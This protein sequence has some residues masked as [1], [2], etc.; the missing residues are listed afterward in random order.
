M[1]FSGVGTLPA[2]SASAPCR[3][4]S[5]PFRPLSRTMTF[6]TRSIPGHRSE[7][8][9]M[10]RW[11]S[12]LAQSPPTLLRL[13]AATHRVSLPR[14]CTPAERLRR[15]RAALCRPAALRALYWSLDPATRAALQSLRATPGG[16]RPDDLSARFGPLRPLHVLRA[17]PTPRSLSERLLL[18]GLLLPRPATPFHPPRYLVPPE[19][20]A[21]LPAPLSPAA[22]APAPV[23]DDLP[24]LAAASALLLASAERPLS[25]RSDGRLTA[26]ARRALAPRLAPLAPSEAATLADWTLPLLVALGALV[27]AG[28]ALVPGPAAAR[29]LSLPPAAHLERLRAAWTGLPRPE[30]WL[31][32][33]RVRVRGL[34]A[35]ALR[36]RLLTWAGY[37][38][39]EAAQQPDRGYAIL[40]AA[41]G[42]LADGTT[43]SLSGPARRGPWAARR[44]A[45]VW[46]TACQGPLRWLGVLPAGY[47]AAPEPPGGDAVSPATCPAAPASA[48]VAVGWM[49]GCLEAAVASVTPAALPAPPPACTTTPS[50]HVHLDAPQAAL[51]HSAPGR[52]APQSAIQT[53]QSAMLSRLHSPAPEAWTWTPDGRLHLPRARDLPEALTVAAFGR[54]ESNTATTLVYRLGPAEVAAATSHGH[55]P[56]RLAATLRRHGGVP[57]HLAGTLRAT[58]GLRLTRRAVL[59]SDDPDDL[60][61]ALRASRA[62]RQ[63]L[64]AQ[65]APGVA[66]VAP[67]REAALTRAL[68]RTGRS[69]SVTPG[70]EPPPAVDALPPQPAGEGGHSASTEPW[71]CDDESG[72]AYTLTLRPLHPSTPSPPAPTSVPITEALRVLQAALR[73]RGVARLYYHGARD[74]APRE[75]LV[76]PLRLETHGPVT[77]LHA[78]C[79]TAQA[80]RCFRLDR[81]VGIE[82]AKADAAHPARPPARAA[83]TAPVRSQGLLALEP[84]REAGA[85]RVWLM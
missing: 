58:G 14:R 69:L 82:G 63:A 56:A 5:L 80:E 72:S 46:A 26:A 21:W 68:A 11:A 40:A 2:L 25:V 9:R 44:A 51:R 61:R 6:N 30:P 74:A 49:V 54:W 17:D 45:A 32:A 84:P 12:V 36:R 62:A 65:L 15:L 3:C 52:L 33:L 31:T 34:D 10:N 85:L 71:T 43:H 50:H 42:P 1:R 67:G 8:N 41:L 66:L 18:L 77:Y 48:N 28:A 76:C 55:D 19:V 24:A 27:P 20:R 53:R 16:L 75:R 38:A 47:A 37:L 59:L 73:Q 23:G 39:P 64:E 70:A 57:A 83:R 4:C 22:A 79:L 81:V 78:Y 35:P 13:I 7:I 60:T 29:L